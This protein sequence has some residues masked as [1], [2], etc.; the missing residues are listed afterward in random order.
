MPNKAIAIIHDEH[1][2]LATV[3]SAL[4]HLV[5]QAQST[6]S[7]PDFQMLWAMLYYIESF[8][9]RLHH[10]KEEHYLFRLLE[11]RTHEIDD[12]LSE[13]RQQHVEGSAQ[14]KSLF[15][16]L[17]RLQAGM[18]DNIGEFSSAVNRYAADTWRHMNLEEHVVFPTA[19]RSLTEQDWE[20]IANAFGENGDPRFGAEPDAEFRDLFRRIIKLKPGQSPTA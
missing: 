13:L 9:E 12:T 20:E 17:R 14:V 1:R 19:L 15:Q 4:Q 10:P 16:A 18:A 3:I 5:R 8:P 11:Q 7:P 2:S 6:Q